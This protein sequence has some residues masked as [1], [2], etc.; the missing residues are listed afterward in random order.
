MLLDEP[1]ND[2]DLDTLRALEDFLDDWPG[3]VVTVS[4]DRAFLDR[5]TDELLA[6]DGHRGV[7]WIRGGVAA[8]LKQRSDT[9]SPS[10]PPATNFVGTPRLTRSVPTKFV[11]GP[12][13]ST[14]RRQIGQAERS[15]AS[16]AV[17]RDAL[18]AEMSTTNAHWELASLSERLAAAQAKVDAAEEHWLHLAHQAEELGLEL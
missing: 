16:A 12:S 2:L 18:A 6:L 4:H 17:A 14:V 10:S 15:L 13:P 3:I 5:A 1:T 7:R 9:P 11:N 8:W